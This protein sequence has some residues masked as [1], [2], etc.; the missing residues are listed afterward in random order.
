M[1]R[2]GARRRW[3]IGILAVLVIAGAF[4]APSVCGVPEVEQ[5][6]AQPKFKDVRTALE[7]MYLVKSEFYKPVSLSKLLQAY[8]AKGT[9]PGMLEVLG[10][11]YTRYMTP[12]DFDALRSDSAGVFGGIGILV[13]IRDEK[14]T[15]ISPI[16]NTP[17]MRAGLM[18]GDCIV[19]IDGVPTE[20][21]V[22][23]RAVS[24]MR[25]EPGTEVTLVVERRYPAGRTEVKIIRDIIDAPS[26]RAYMIDKESGIGYIELRSFSQK[27]GHDI[28]DDVKKLLSMGMRGLILDLRYNGGGLVTQAVEVSSKFIPA[29]PVMHVQGRDGVKSTLRTAGVRI[30]DI[31]M[32][33]LVNEYTA[34]ASEIVSGALQDT[35]VATIV[36]VPTFGKGL[37]Q[38]L[39]PLSDGSGLAVTTQIYLTAGGRGITPDTPIQPD[40]VV[41]ALSPEELETIM[42]RKSSTS[43][44][45]G[46]VTSDDL[47]RIDPEL[48]PQF[49]KAVEVLKEKIQASSAASGAA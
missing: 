29:G 31:P 45:K 7:T 38:T 30:T 15:I 41:E 14:I 2:D 13:G 34:S 42:S 36:G 43:G 28:E 5:G 40:V 21:M 47:L 8:L 33:V 20:G 18:P 37:V 3:I 17:G 19:E 39:Y 22:L 10:D 4:L 46:P 9:V 32:V 16:E 49:R 11:P 44:P 12:D 24:M 6:E 1:N 23:D 26:T 27:A 25:G 48:D 35:K